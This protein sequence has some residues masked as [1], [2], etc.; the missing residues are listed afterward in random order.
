MTVEDF[1]QSTIDGYGYDAKIKYLDKKPDRQF[2]LDNSKLA[3]ALN[4]IS[5]GPFDYDKVLYELG[6]KL[7]EI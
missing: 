3:T 7:C 2:V 6:K 5:I 1:I 4:M